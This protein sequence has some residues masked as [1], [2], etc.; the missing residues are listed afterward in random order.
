MKN[1]QQM[2]TSAQKG[3]T[4]IELMIVVAIIGI[5]AAVALPAYQGYVA[6]GQATACYSELVPGKTQFEILSLDGTGVTAAD[7]G[8]EVN[9]GAAVACA[10]HALTATTIVGTL[11]GD[12]TVAGATLA[13][14]RVAATGAWSCVATDG[15]GSTV[16]A[17]NPERLPVECR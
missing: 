7:N 14:T 2:K 9:M 8:S 12:V 10:S 13:L 3:F 1:L 5:L 17:D 6:K 15:G 11:Q 16:V 4:L